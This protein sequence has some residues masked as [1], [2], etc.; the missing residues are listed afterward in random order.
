MLSLFT[1]NSH[2]KKLKFHITKDANKNRIFNFVSRIYKETDV[3][4]VT[5]QNFALAW[6]LREEGKKY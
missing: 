5:I 2:G 6:I 1:K 4:Y 3:A